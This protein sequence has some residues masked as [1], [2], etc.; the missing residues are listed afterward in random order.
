MPPLQQGHPSH[1]PPGHSMTPPWNPQPFSS[2]PQPMLQKAL[3]KAGEPSPL[4]IAAMAFAAFLV[5]SLSL[6][7]CLWLRS[8]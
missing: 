2:A 8:H 5:I 6:G 3:P 7:S 1:P 4:A